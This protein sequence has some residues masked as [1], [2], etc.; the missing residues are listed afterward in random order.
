MCY[1]ISMERG[2]ELCEDLLGET[3]GCILERHLIKSWILLKFQ[4]DDP[5]PHPRAQT[6]WL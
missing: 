3:Y 1:I 6:P 2:N 4:L 5:L